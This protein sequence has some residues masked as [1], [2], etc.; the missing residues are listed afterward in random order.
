MGFR[1]I[2][3][4]MYAQADKYVSGNYWKHCLLLL[5][6]IFTLNEE[7]NMYH[8]AEGKT[9][10]GK[11]CRRGQPS[12]KEIYYLREAF[13]PLI[14]L[15]M[16]LSECL[17]SRGGTLSVAWGSEDTLLPTK[18]SQTTRKLSMLDFPVSRVKA[19]TDGISAYI[20]VTFCCGKWPTVTRTFIIVAFYH[21]LSLCICIESVMD[22]HY[23]QTKIY[24]PSTVP[25]THPVGYGEVKA[26]QKPS[27]IFLSSLNRWKSIH[28]C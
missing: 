18:F 25:Q 8:K 20:C 13:K 10:C 17:M 24:L 11:T 26:P 5:A 9:F 19:W 6:F 7:R 16:G 3:E 21:N 28:L 12:C 22:G 27:F 1:R 14:I 23:S 2:R 4:R 15:S